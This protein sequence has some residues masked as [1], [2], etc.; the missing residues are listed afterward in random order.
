MRM[1]RISS[2]RTIAITIAAAAAAFS[3]PG[4]RPAPAPLQPAAAQAH[5]PHAATRHVAHQ[6][7]RISFYGRRFAQRSTASGEPFDPHAFTMAHRTL[8]FGTLVRVTNLRNHRSVI[9]RVNDRGPHVDRRVA[10]V[11]LAAARALGMVRLG[12]VEAR[13]EPLEVPTADA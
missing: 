11:S 9:V 1:P 6:R 5:H 4:A 2:G 3:A 10:D 12:V 13:L 8:P 7:G